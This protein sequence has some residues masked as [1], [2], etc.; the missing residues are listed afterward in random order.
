MAADQSTRGLTEREICQVVDHAVEWVADMLGIAD[1]ARYAELDDT[2]GAA[3]NH[4]L[5]QVKA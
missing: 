1:D 4:E 2:L 3:L 5:R